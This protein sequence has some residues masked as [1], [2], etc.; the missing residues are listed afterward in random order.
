MSAIPTYPISS[1][2]PIIRGNLD[3]E[4]ASAPAAFQPMAIH[5]ASNS[6]SCQHLETHAFSSRQP[7]EWNTGPLE[8][9]Q[10]AQWS[11]FKVALPVLTQNKDKHPP[12]LVTPSCYPNLVNYLWFWT[13]HTKQVSQATHDPHTLYT[14]TPRPDPMQQ[15]PSTNSCRAVSPSSPG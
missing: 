12:K 8:L 9:T 14:C 6:T 15:L 1:P 2:V 5:S 11:H 13:T 10:L 3:T 7:R 4:T